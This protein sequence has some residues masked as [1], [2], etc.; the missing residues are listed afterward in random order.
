MKARWLAVLA[1]V[2]VGAISAALLAIP[3]VRATEQQV[4]LRWLFQ[5][6]GPVDPPR[7]LRS[8]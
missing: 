6:R 2:G 3:A 8:C 1:G 4:G 7:T 5:L